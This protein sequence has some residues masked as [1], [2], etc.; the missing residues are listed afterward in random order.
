MLQNEI[1]KNEWFIGALNRSAQNTF[2]IP[3]LCQ[4]LALLIFS[5]AQTAKCIPVKSGEQKKKKKTGKHA[6]CI[7]IPASRIRECAGII[8]IMNTVLSNV[9]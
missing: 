1:L 8:S 5:T 6:P 9:S 4:P 7:K 3:L 2:R